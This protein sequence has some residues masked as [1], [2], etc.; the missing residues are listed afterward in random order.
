MG[1]N[2]YVPEYIQPFRGAPWGVFVWLL[3][4]AAPLVHGETAQSNPIDVNGA[5]VVVPA[6]GSP[7]V[8][9]AAAMLVEEVEKRTTIRW[10]VTSAWPQGGQPVVALGLQ[11]SLTDFACPWE[12]A[13]AG[14]GQAGP[15]GYHLQVFSDGQ[16]QGVAVV[17]TDERGVLFG[18]GRLLRELRMSDR[19][20][21]VERG[22]DIVTSPLVAVAY[23]DGH[24][25]S[26]VR[27]AETRF[28]DGLRVRYTDLDPAARYKVR[29]VYAGDKLDAK[30]R[31]FANETI[32]IHPY[33]PKEVPLRLVEFEIP[34]EA[35]ATGDL[36]LTWYQ[37]PG[38]GGSGRGCQVAEVWLMRDEDP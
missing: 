14:G 23:R 26:W 29:A 2:Q 24:R 37:E 1:A 34:K 16:V 9:Q 7:R 5:T 30:L 13:L 28:E 3:L 8:Q 4:A 19:S 20:V 35:T 25:M 15:E 18:V 36:T 10:P 21:Y 12:Q 38:G 33:I 11:E 31:L 22:L 17:G 6:T 27:N 32:A